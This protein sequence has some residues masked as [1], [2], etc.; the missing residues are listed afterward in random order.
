MSED[1]G[2]ERGFLRARCP[3]EKIYYSGS[4]GLAR[5]EKIEP[6]FVQTLR[7]IQRKGAAGISSLREV[8]E[9]DYYPSKGRRSP[10]MKKLPRSA[11]F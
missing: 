11:T 4:C 7:T 5:R 10:L 8:I 6:V 2:G 9:D 3:P 1:P